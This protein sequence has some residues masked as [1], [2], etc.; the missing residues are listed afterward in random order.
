MGEGA[1]EYGD[2]LV[3]ISEHKTCP[4]Y[5]IQKFSI[6]NVSV[7]Y[8]LVL[9]VGLFARQCNYGICSVRS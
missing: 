9:I 8:C 5:I 3:K 2:I 4:D 6:T 7:P 1:R